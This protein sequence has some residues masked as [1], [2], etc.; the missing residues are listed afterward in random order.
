MKTELVKAGESYPATIDRLSQIPLLTQEEEYALAVRYRQYGDVEAAEKLAIHSFRYVASVASKYCKGQNFPD[1][2]QQGCIGL[3]KA[4][5]AFDP[6]RG[7]PLIGFADI[8][9]KSEILDY[10]R[11]NN[12]I[13]KITGTKQ[14]KRIYHNIGNYTDVNGQLDAERMAEELDVP[15]DKVWEVATRINGQDTLSINYVRSDHGEDDEF[16]EIED[17]SYSPLTVIEQDSAAN[18]LASCLHVL[19]DQQL[20]IITHTYLNED[21]KTLTEL[22]DDLGM[23]SPQAVDHHRKRA[24]I[25]MKEELE[26]KK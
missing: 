18:I 10:I 16:L 19:N 17:D 9:I 20:Y 22:A 1:Y 4:I 11:Q 7:V 15:I 3:L 25:L 14:I 12:N 5:K 8:W 24:L 23:K 2:F 6:D 26:R 13:V 21:K